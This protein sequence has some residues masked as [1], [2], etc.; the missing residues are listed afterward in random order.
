LLLKGLVR[1]KVQTLG[2]TIAPVAH[3]EV[4]RIFLAFVVS[5]GIKL[6]QID[7]KSVFLIGVIQE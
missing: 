3:L 5:K 6:Y 7:M 2:E 1:R 4:I